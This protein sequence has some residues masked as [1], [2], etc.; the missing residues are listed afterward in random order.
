[1]KSEQFEVVVIGG[2]QAGLAMSYYLTEQRREHV[3][4]EK[5]R[6]VESWRTRRWDS[7]RLIA[8]N[9][10]LRLP[11]YAYDGPDPDGFMG[12]DEVV[13]RL[14]GYARSFNAPVREHTPVTSVEHDADGVQFR[15]NTTNGMYRA[16]QVVIATGALQKTKIPAYAGSIPASIVQLDPSDY[17]NPSALLPGSVLIVGSGQTGCQIAEELRR[18]GRTVFLS[19]GRCWWVPRRYQEKDIAFWFRLSGYFDQTVDDLPPGSR[20]GKVNPQMSG[21]DGGH[22]ISLHT[23][24]AE[25]VVLLGRI[26]RVQD[27]TIFMAPDLLANLEWGEEQAFD[28]LRTFDEKILAEAFDAPEQSLDAYRRS[29][30]DLARRSPAELDLAAADVSTVIWAT[31]YQPGLDW[32]KVPIL[33]A[34]GYPNQRRGVT[35]VP[36]L[37]ILGLDW[38]YKLKS[39]IFAGVG[40]DAEYLAG[41]IAARAGSA[42]RPSLAASAS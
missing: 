6:I 32:V 8:P 13:E 14:E 31:G 4:L 42:H 9:W 35:D 15:V 28:L 3:V 10:S 12:K 22:D 40:E 16:S 5:D 38:L 25:G 33:A 39:G 26:Q 17:R 24:S 30:E 2:G 37:Y 41:V 29:S 36:G 20:T 1:M 23:L 19:V 27:G 18:A 21:G 7:L 34:D 11:G